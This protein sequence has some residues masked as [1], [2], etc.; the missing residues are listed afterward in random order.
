[1]KKPLGRIF[2]AAAAIVLLSALA[3]PA[4]G[5]LLEDE[6]NT[7]DIVKK[8]K[9]SVVFI[10]N[11][12]LVRDFFF[13]EEKAPRVINKLECGYPRFVIH[14]LVAELAAQLAPG[15]ARPPVALPPNSDSMPFKDL[16]VAW[17]KAG[18]DRP[19]DAEEQR[20]LGRGRDVIATRFLFR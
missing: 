1:M 16:L 17:G 18:A 11:I 6:K 12:G 14:P 5:Q 15:P 9:N 8:T 2:G 20:P 10:T 19:D 13:N 3:V 7:I 4:R